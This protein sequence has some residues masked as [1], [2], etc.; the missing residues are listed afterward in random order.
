MNQY[1]GV[2]PSTFQVVYIRWKMATFKGKYVG[3]YSLHGAFGIVFWG[4]LWENYGKG[5]H[6][7]KRDAYLEPKWLLFGLGSTTKKEDKVWH[8][9]GCYQICIHKQRYIY[10]YIYILIYAYI[11]IIIIYIHNI[12]TYAY[13]YCNYMPVIQKWPFYPGLLEVAQNISGRSC[14]RLNN[15]W[16]FPKGNLLLQ[17]LIC[18]KKTCLGFV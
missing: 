18:R 10:I 6:Y 5:D 8:I 1:M 7:R 12:F 17:G 16:W 2:A 11:F 14:L 4:S 3:K 15:K 9:P 13:I